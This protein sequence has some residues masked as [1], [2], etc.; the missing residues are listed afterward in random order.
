MG[1]LLIL[2]AFALKL[3]VGLWSSDKRKME[4]A[5]SFAQPLITISA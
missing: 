5:E 1:G 3:Q 4:L 2:Q